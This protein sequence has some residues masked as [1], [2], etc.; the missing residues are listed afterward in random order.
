MRTLSLVTFLALGSFGLA[1]ALAAP[2]DAKPA[3]DGAQ[4]ATDASK[5]LESLEKGIA[6]ASTIG[7]LGAELHL[8]PD[9]WRYEI[10]SRLG[11]AASSGKDIALWVEEMAKAKETAKLRQRLSGKAGFRLDLLPTESEGG[12]PGHRAVQ[13]FDANLTKS[14]SVKLGGAVAEWQI[15]REPRGLEVKTVRIARHWTSRNYRLVPVTTPLKPEM[16]R[17]VRRGERASVWGVLPASAV[18]AKSGTLSLRLNDYDQLIGHY[19]DEHIVDL[20]VESN[21]FEREL[22]F[23]L[24]SE[25]PFFFPEPPQSLAEFLDWAVKALSGKT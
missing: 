18:A 6:I 4:L 19:S 13:M 11:D 22:S 5:Y 10:C 21:T 9:A 20:N 24:E 8:F 12:A 25:L 3:F 23:T 15:W 14:F 2:E 1:A 16:P 17:A 7:P